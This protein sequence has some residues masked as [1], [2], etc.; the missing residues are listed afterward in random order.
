M[1]KFIYLL[2][3]GLLLFSILSCKNDPIF[4]SIEKEIALEDPVI[5]G[6]V[7]SLTEAG[8]KLY[9]ANGNLFVKNSADMRGWIVA[10]AQPNGYIIRT[11]SDSSHLYVLTRDKVLF[12][13]PLAE[14]LSWTQISEAVVELFDNNA[15]LSTDKKA[16]FT[17]ES[18]VFEISDG[19]SSA[20]SNNGASK[21]SITA[22]YINGQT[23]FSSS[24]L[25]TSDREATLYRVSSTNIEYST[26]NVNWTP[27]TVTITAPLSLEF[28]SNDT[29]ESLLVGTESGIIQFSITEEIPSATV[30]TVPGVNADASFGTSH[31]PSIFSYPFKSGSIYIG[32]LKEDDSKSTHF[33]GYYTSRPNWNLE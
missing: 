31:V 10:N 21:D 24:I 25:F 16:F 28:Y 30:S 19:T 1:K 6:N 15:L 3:A 33:W 18:A 4:Y 7:Y 17:T 20:V 27:I 23:Y 29:L 9:V 12:S 8:S 22:E 13:S 26:N 5:H 11:A 2:F 14:I 32:S